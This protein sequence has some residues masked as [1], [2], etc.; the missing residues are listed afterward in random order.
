MNNLICLNAR[1]LSFIPHDNTVNCIL[2]LYQ[3]THFKSWIKSLSNKILRDQKFA[4][5]DLIVLKILSWSYLAMSDC[6][7]SVETV[8]RLHINVYDT[9]WR[10]YKYVSLC[11]GFGE[12]QNKIV[13]KALHIYHVICL[14]ALANT[15]VRFQSI[16]FLFHLNEWNCF[17]ISS[18]K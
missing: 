2:K 14:Y 1:Q 13:S 12:S 10:Y 3:I 11:T 6:T 15:Q 7:E 9:Y 17:F 5:S 18:F 4:L 8:N 16:F